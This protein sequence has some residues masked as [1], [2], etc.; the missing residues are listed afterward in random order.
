MAQYFGCRYK[1]D[2]SQNTEPRTSLLLRHSR[3]DRP[4]CATRRCLTRTFLNSTKSLKLESLLMVGN[5][6]SPNEARR[7]RQS[8]SQG[9]SLL[10]GVW[11]AQGCA[12]ALQGRCACA[13]LTRFEPVSMT[14][15]AFLARAEA[16]TMRCFSRSSPQRALIVLHKLLD[17][18][19]REL[20]CDVE[21]L[22]GLV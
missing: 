5:E 19:G 4:F 13:W 7:G 2:G 16:K 18:L 9:I 21:I 22:P 14:G 6:K 1:S 8:C 15:A 20:M 12:R 10:I 3:T 17:P 11:W